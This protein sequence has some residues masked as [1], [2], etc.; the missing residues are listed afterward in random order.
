[1]SI[2][3]PHRRSPDEL[4]SLPERDQLELRDG[5]LSEKHISEEFCWVG[6]EV[7]FWLRSALVSDPVGWVLGEGVGYRCFDEPD[8]IRRAD[9]SF[10]LRERRPE[11][12]LNVGFTEL[13]PDLAVEVVSPRDLVDEV[14]G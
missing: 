8:R 6:S 3:A 2:A 10:I 11:G 14:G 12:P 1:M 5:I 4:L 7:L 13:A 9:V